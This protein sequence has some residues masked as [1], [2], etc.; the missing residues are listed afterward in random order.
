M[1]E[2]HQKAQPL[3]AHLIELRRRLIWCTLIYAAAFGLCYEFADRIYDALAQPLVSA[4]DG[5][6]RRFIY[7][8]LTEAFVTYL[9]V[10]AWG[11]LCLTFPF[12]MMQVWLF[13]APGLY[14]HERRA[15]S[16]FLVLTPVLFIAGAALAYFFVIP[17]AWKFFLGFEQAAMPGTL[18]IQLEARM[19][20]YLNLTMSLL[21][22]FGA[23]FQL[24]VLMLLLVRFGLLAPTDL[25][26]HRRYAILIIFIVAAVLTPPDIL[27]QFCL[28]I[29][30]MALYEGGI[31]MAKAMYPNNK[32][33][34]K[35]TEQVLHD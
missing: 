32:T 35:T 21:F 31:L 24:P 34:E 12:I 18:P 20:E 15:V 8:S 30:L 11:A 3:L 29:P 25:A 10:S 6:Q 14:K 19:A 17:L 33:Q 9:R 26:K 7:T 1:T 27:S 16:P 22:A 4:L 13:I 2:L 23:A 5:E 28:A